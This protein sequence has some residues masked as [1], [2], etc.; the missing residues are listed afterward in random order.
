MWITRGGK[1]SPVINEDVG[2]PQYSGV[3]SL[4]EACLWLKRNMERS[5]ETALIILSPPHVQVTALHCTVST[6][7]VIVTIP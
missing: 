3:V 7:T 5:P 4:A 1:R 6:F 2:D